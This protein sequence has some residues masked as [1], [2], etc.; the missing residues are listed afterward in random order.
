[1][2]EE[3]WS[4]VD[5]YLA[6]ALLPADPILDAV[7]A[8][9]AAA[10]L[11]KIDVSPLFG[12]LLHLLAR[13]RGAKSILEVGTLGGYSTIWLAR[14]LPAD[15]RLITLEVNPLHAET[16][17]ANLLKA[18]V[19]HRV[20]LRLG[21]ARETLRQLDEEHRGPFDLIFIDADKPGNPDYF[22]WTLKLS[23][24]ETLIIVD[25]VVRGGAV[26][27]AD[28]DDPS[29][30]GVRRMHELIAAEPRVTATAIQMVG[31]KGYDGFTLV[32][33]QAVA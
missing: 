15:G 32:L 19:D 9:N 8:A 6:S 14:A 26:A 1:M 17:R 24:P 22:Q 21:D 20:E 7:L 13:I 33:V 25:N 28:S 2:N 10:G 4:A 5:A 23:R 31:V 29:V 30:R 16:A 18:G 3:L 11:P 27:D 12:K